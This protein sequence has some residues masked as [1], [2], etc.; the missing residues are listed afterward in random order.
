MTI[1]IVVPTFERLDHLRPALESVFAQTWLD[2]DLIVADDGSGEDVQTY[3]RT[4]EARPRVKVVRLAHTGNPAAVRNAG[5]RAATGTHVAFLDSDDLW[6]PRKLE[7]QIATLGDRRWGYTAFRRVDRAGQV[8]PEERTRPWT[9]HAGDIFRQVVTGAA[10]IRTPSVIATR[11]LLGEAGGFDETLR[12]CE[13]Y[14]LWM[15]LALRAPAAVVDEP[16]VD[17]RL[18][19]RNLS[20]DWASAFH[21]RD[22]AL[23]KLESLVPAPLRAFVR[24]ERARNGAGLVSEHARRGERAAVARALLAGAPH[25]WR[26]PEWW[27]R[28]LRALTRR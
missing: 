24:R 23:A 8:L 16:L 27:W 3:L 2:W 4:L 25:A 13:D 21:G 22:R 20:R 18:H 12:S 15:R 11:E 1:S 28:A 26:Y 5:L 7:R 17:V 10:S 6:A 14:D 9:P 19:D